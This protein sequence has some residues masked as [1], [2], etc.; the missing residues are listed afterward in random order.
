MTDVLTLVDHRGAP[1]ESSSWRTYLVLAHTLGGSARIVVRSTIGR[2]APENVEDVLRRWTKH[3]FDISKVTLVVRGRERVERTGPCVMIGNHVSLL[4][5]PCIVASYPGAVRF[6]AKIELRRVPVFGKALE[7]A[8][9]VFVNREN[10]A[11]AIRQLA[12]ARELLVKGTSLW[13][14]AE[15][16]RSRDGRLHAF[17]KG[18]FH[19]AVDL[20]VPLVPT[21]IQGTLDVIPPDQWR[22][23][24]G[25]TVTVA[26]GEPIPTTGMTREDLP[27]L[28]KRARQHMLELAHACGAP[29]EIDAAPDAP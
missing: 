29:P 27:A 8:G 13:V 21:W 20:A 3:V 19:L 4:D 28:M 15:G 18:A 7:D 14:A 22:S 12:G 25:Q 24:T 23:R 2:L 16:S 26:Y 9:V 11:L 6:V 10:R 5:T 17:K 1:A